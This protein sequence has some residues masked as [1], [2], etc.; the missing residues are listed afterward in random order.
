MTKTHENARNTRTNG[1]GTPA[2]RRGAL[3]SVITAR[4]SSAERDA[5]RRNTTAKS[6]SKLRIVSGKIADDINAHKRTLCVQKRRAAFFRG[7]KAGY[8]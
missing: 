1:E 5:H 2:G 6:E 3:Q 7:P 4:R 8:R